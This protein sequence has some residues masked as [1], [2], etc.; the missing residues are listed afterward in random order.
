MYLARTSLLALLILVIVIS[1][2]A[3]G[4]SEKAVKGICDL[5]EKKGINRMM[6]PKGSFDPT[7]FDPEQFDPMMLEATWEQVRTSVRR[8][9]ERETNVEL[10]EGSLKLYVALVSEASSTSNDGRVVMSK[11]YKIVFIVFDP[12]VRD[13]LMRSLSLPE[14]C[15]QEWKSVYET[16]TMSAVS[17]TV[18][19]N[20]IGKVTSR[21]VSSSPR[22]RR[23]GFATR[24]PIYLRDKVQIV[25][26]WRRSGRYGGYD[27]FWR[28]FFQVKRTNRRG[29]YLVTVRG[30]VSRNL[31]GAQTN[32]MEYLGT[33]EFDSRFEVP[34]GT[35]RVNKVKKYVDGP[36]QGSMPQEP[37]AVSN[38]GQLA[39]TLLNQYYKL[40]TE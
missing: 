11:R 36:K 30:Q 33:E 15:F 14:E 35:E 5:L 10:Y 9:I 19:W 13:V 25:T 24:A 4:D 18:R 28:L 27:M 2:A 26:S 17:L 12:S 21:F 7:S 23:L 31:P 22:I 38:S 29:E 39:T 37:S 20:N 34:I 40:L 8:I 32:R 16:R 3:F 1:P 6:F